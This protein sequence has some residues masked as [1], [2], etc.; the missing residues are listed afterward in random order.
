VREH[1][2]LPVN[3]YNT[4]TLP[5]YIYKR[6]SALT[7]IC[8]YTQRMQPCSRSCSTNCA[9]DTRSRR[10]HS[11]RSSR[12]SGRKRVRYCPRV[13]TSSNSNS[14]LSRSI[15]LRTL[16]CVAC[17]MTRWPVENVDEQDTAAANKKQILFSLIIRLSSCQPGR[18]F[19]GMRVAAPSSTEL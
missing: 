18:S 10:S 11:A 19:E 9:I 5:L 3:L 13:R 7:S 2:S 15:Q 14:S 17:M 8:F 6:Y 1:R 4:N 16:L 12:E